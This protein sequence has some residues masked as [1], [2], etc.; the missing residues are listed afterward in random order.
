MPSLQWAGMY[1]VIWPIAVGFLFISIAA[2]LF[3]VIPSGA[4]LIARSSGKVFFAVGYAI[5]VCYTLLGIVTFLLYFLRRGSG[6]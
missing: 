1:D 2:L 5:L 6:V 4:H 3:P